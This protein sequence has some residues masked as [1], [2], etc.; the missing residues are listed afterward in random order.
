[1]SC[2]RSHGHRSAR[3]LPATVETVVASGPHHHD[4]GCAGG[5][6]AGL[7]TLRR[8]AGAADSGFS[9]AVAPD[10]T[11]RDAELRS[12][13]ARL[14]S[15]LLRTSCR[16][17]LLSSGR[18]WA[19]GRHWRS[20]ERSAPAGRCKPPER[21]QG[22]MRADRLCRQTCLR[23]ELRCSTAAEHRTVPMFAAQRVRG[24]QARPRPRG[25]V[26]RRGR[27]RAG[28]RVG[29]VLSQ[30][31]STASRRRRR[32]TGLWRACL[33]AAHHLPAGGG[34]GWTGQRCVC[35]GKADDAGEQSI[36]AGAVAR[37]IFPHNLRR[38]RRLARP[39]T[40]GAATADGD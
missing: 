32:A 29:R 9:A 21:T 18:Q 16:P 30:Q 7:G 20:C 25:K 31:P 10:P 1:M 12:A 4:L 35:R 40:R 22:C 11:R 24:A 27:T 3:R 19:S 14:R 37:P 17:Q 5:L 8:L 15:A 13:R 38:D 33:R 34:C 28:L 26:L 36:R 39:R 2:A 23:N 6:E